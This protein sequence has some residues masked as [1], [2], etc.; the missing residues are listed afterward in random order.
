MRQGTVIKIIFGILTCLLVS[1]CS[2]YIVHNATWLLGDD[3]TTLVYTGWDKP[4]FG[5]FVSPTLGRFFP[6]NYTIYDILLPFFNGQIPPA[7]HYTIHILCFILFVGSFMW[8]SVFILREQPVWYRYAISF[9]IVVLIIGRTFINYAQCWTG[10]WMIF[11][12][13]PIFIL[14]SLR[15][16]E[17]T[18]WWYALIALVTINYVIYYYEIV[19]II[20]LTIGASA[21]LFS[22]M[23]L[24]KPEKTYYASLV[25]SGLL[26]LILYVVLVLPK[27]ENFYSH[28]SDMTLFQNAMKMFIAQKIMWFS[29]TFLAVR[30]YCL[31]R[32]KAS[33]CLYDGL[34]LASCAYFCGAAL[35]G[36]D[37]TLYYNP[38]VLIAIPAILAYSIR[39]LKINRALVLFLI[40]AVFYVRYIP[41]HIKSN[42]EVR[43]S[44]Y[45]NVQ[46]YIK[47]LNGRDAFFYEPNDDSLDKWN[48]EERHIKRFYLEKVAGWYMKN[49]SFTIESKDNFTGEPGLWQVPSESSK[50]FAEECPDANCIIDLGDS[51]VYAF[52]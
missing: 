13:L 40:L 52:E 49:E 4:I 29:V 38:A 42:Q 18:R 19:F 28:H 22:F 32:K 45:A 37:F 33:F 24:S 15:F 8:L 2:Y 44:T 27:V 47:Q 20:P 30:A 48:W 51:K 31:I 5:F 9:L 41:N 6:L 14:C 43:L 39:Y 3:C 21:L 12:V 26:F 50:L 25:A 11:T 23:R 10:I 36:L 46:L 35:L 1:L 16:L 34:L 7:A 17:T